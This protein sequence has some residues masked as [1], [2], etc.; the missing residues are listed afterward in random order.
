MG[1][2][3]VKRL[4]DSALEKEPSERAAFL[5][6]LDALDPS[7]REEVESLLAAEGEDSFFEK[8]PPGVHS[9]KE[10]KAEKS[11]AVRP[12]DSAPKVPDRIGP[13]RLLREIGEG[14]MGIVYEAEQE[15]PVRRKVALKLIKWGMD[16]KAVVAR[17][18][19]ER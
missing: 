15:R 10:N 12:L 4:F 16:T 13:Y 1:Q 5:E 3:Q 9:L 18:E 6:G 7:V 11:T 2:K 17:F 14:G 19:S 8:P